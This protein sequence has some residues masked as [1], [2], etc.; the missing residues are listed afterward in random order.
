MVFMSIEEIVRERT[1]RALTHGSDVDGVVCAALILKR[2]P[3]ASIDLGS[4]SADLSGEYEIVADLPLQKGLRTKIW[5]DHHANAK[6]EGICEQMIYDPSS[7]SAAS[8]LAKFLDVRAPELVEIAD[9]ADSAGYLT[10][11]PFDLAGEYDIAWDVNDAVKAI[12]YK[13]R[14]IELAKFLAFGNL[15]ELKRK[16]MIEILYSRNSRKR[17]FDA[18]RDL[19][20]EVKLRGADAAIIIMQDDRILRPG[21]VAHALLS[22]GVKVCVI[23]F[24]DGR[25]WIN[26]G[27]D[28]DGVSAVGIAERYGGGGHAKSAGAKVGLENLEKLKKELE[29]LGLRTVFVDLK[30]FVG[31]GREKV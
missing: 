6:V 14:F 11:P 4:P 20:Q 28:F 21:T 31:R 8:L 24:S 22:G 3:D 2:F 27:R 23:I 7:K 10:E 13:G 30:E 5:V 9:R 18:V 12:F 26:V 19:P 29:E 17:T 16:F 1:V 15:H 25:G